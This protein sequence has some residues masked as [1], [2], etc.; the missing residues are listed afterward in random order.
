MIIFTTTIT[1]ALQL[2][3]RGSPLQM[4]VALA[5]VGR[6]YSLWFEVTLVLHGPTCR[7]R[8]AV[9]NCKAPLTLRS[10][11]DLSQ[12]AELVGLLHH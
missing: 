2:P 8:A 3:G 9:F 1:S 7:H 5:D 4:S 10:R 12:D 6:A 11:D